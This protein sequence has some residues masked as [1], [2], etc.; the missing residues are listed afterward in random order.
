M[1][2]PLAEIVSRKL[3]GTTIPGSGA[4]AANLTLWLGMLGAAIAARDGKLLTL[5][6]GEFLPKGR[7][8]EIAHIISAAVGAMVSTMLALGGVALVVSDRLAGDTIA[9]L[10][11]TWVADLALPIG[12]GLIAIRLVWRASPHHVGRAL[13]A[14]GIV[15]GLVL[16]QYRAVL[17]NQSLLPWMLLLVIAGVVGAPI[18]ALLGGIALFA[19]LTRGNPPV[20]LPMMGY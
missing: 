9:D 19:S 7:I 11:P 10:V 17:E 13:A 2:L 14:L 1:L 15:A 3:F 20:V 16:N 8:G 4:F 18:F 5:A 12:F 6:T